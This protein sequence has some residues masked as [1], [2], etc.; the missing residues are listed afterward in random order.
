MAR[1][2]LELHALRRRRT[3]EQLGKRE[4]VEPERVQ[5][6]EYRVAEVGLRQARESGGGRIREPWNLDITYALEIPQH[7]RWQAIRNLAARVDRPGRQER[8]CERCLIAS[9]GKQHRIGS[10]RCELAAQKG[11]HIGVR[12]EPVRARCATSLVLPR[13]NEGAREASL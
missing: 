10:L 8:L 2:A 6:L 9:D 12:I 1:R 4:R 11:K 5:A 7:R 13:G 3:R